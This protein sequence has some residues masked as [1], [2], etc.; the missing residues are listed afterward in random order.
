[1]FAVAP[2]ADYVQ[3]RGLVR[4]RV[5]HGFGALYDFGLS[6]DFLLSVELIFVYYRWV[7]HLGFTLNDAEKIFIFHLFKWVVKLCL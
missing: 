2:E 3:L 6:T 5:E 4:E 7:G 1:M